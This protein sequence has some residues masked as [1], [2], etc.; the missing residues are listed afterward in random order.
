MKVFYDFEFIED[1]VTIDPISV[2]LV[3]DKGRTYYAVNFDADWERI[4]KHDWLMEN[5]WPHLPLR[6]RKTGGLTVNQNDPGVLDRTSVLLKPR[7]VIA[8]EVREFLLSPGERVELWADCGAYDH[9]ALMQLCWGPMI[10]KP[11]AM[12]F[13][14]ND[15]MQ[16]AEALGV[17]EEQFPARRP[18]LVPHHALDD[19]K[20]DQD[21]YEFLVAHDEE[22]RR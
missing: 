3:D 19:A 6:G 21:L 10:R 20:A 2:G 4:R 22:R 7:W 13:Y 5:V 18:E 16:E 12:P 15:L 9:V 14:T 11:K 8:N 1:G 17:R